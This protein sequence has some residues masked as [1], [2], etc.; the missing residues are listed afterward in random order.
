V[1]AAGLF[2][3]GLGRLIGL[4]FLPASDPLWDSSALLRDDSVVGS[5][6]AGFVGYRARPTVLEVLGYTTYLAAAGW[7]LFGR[8]AQPPLPRAARYR[9]DVAS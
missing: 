1:V 7:L 2:S 6:L 4:G 9:P 8:R 5:F 3:S